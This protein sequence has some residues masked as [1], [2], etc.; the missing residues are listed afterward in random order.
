L[1]IY[2]QLDGTV[3]HGPG[4]AFVLGEASLSWV[5]MEI[6]VTDDETFYA[7][8]TESA[9]STLVETVPVSLQLLQRVDL[10]ILILQELDD[11]IESEGGLLI[12]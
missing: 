6:V 10:L 12:P 11:L 4:L 5:A 8:H 9:L 2:N 1:P 3:R 7:L